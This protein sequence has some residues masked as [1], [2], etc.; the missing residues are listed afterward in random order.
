MTAP[1]VPSRS[2]MWNLLRWLLVLPGA[3]GGYVLIATVISHLSDRVLLLLFS[4]PES[5]LHLFAVASFTAICVGAAVAPRYRFW[6]SCGLTLLL[7]VVIVLVVGNS[8]HAETADPSILLVAASQIATALL[9][10]WLFWWIE[11]RAALRFLR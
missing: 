1:L 7:A 2:A 6:T 5:Y 8:L 4:F 9:A 3:V 10:V 11:H